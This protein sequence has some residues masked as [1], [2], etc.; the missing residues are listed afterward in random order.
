M[1]FW[2]LQRS[3]NA[4]FSKIRSYVGANSILTHPDKHGLCGR[5]G[6]DASQRSRLG[7]G[8]KTTDGREVSSQS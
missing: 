3:C 2:Q 1:V 7:L 6:G 4:N 8:R 5:A